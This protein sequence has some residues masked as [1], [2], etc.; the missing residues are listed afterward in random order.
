M[1][2]GVYLSSIFDNNL[3]SFTGCVITYDIVTGWNP[4]QLYDQF[5]S[6]VIVSPVFLI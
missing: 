6:S 3:I 1:Y 2:N 4:I 5:V